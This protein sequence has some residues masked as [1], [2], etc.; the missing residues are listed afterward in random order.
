MPR[1]GAGKGIQ[2]D[3]C[4][5]SIPSGDGRLVRPRREL[6]VDD[7]IALSSDW[8]DGGGVVPAENLLAVLGG[9]EAG[10]SEGI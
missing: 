1:N 7:L 9:K 3:V 5:G 10:I 2:L 8:R 6:E 4:Q